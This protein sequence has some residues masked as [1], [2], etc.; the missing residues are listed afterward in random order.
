MATQR[1][2]NLMSFTDDSSTGSSAMPM[3]KLSLGRSW[4]TTSEWREISRTETPGRS[5][6]KSDTSRGN[7]EMAAQGWLAMARRPAL[8]SRI[9]TVAACRRSTSPSTRVASA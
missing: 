7:S 5:T 6:R 8:P 2:W 4:L 9:W 1:I 3:S